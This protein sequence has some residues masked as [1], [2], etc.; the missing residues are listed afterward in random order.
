MTQM[1]LIVIGAIVVTG[2]MTPVTRAICALPSRDASQLRAVP[3]SAI[4]PPPAALSASAA[5]AGAAEVSSA[6]A[7]STNETGQQPVQP[8]EEIARNLT[9]PHPNVRVEAMRTLAKAAHPDAIAHIAVLLT[10]PIDE[11]QSEAIDTLIGFYMIDVPKKSRKIA[12]LIEV[13][14]GSRGERAFERGPFILLPRPSPEALKK[15]LAGAMRDQNPKIRLEATYALGALVPPPAGPDAEAAIAANL[16]DPEGNIRL[17]AARVAGAVRA[18]TITDALVAAINDPEEKIK[19]AAMRS[20]GDIRDPRAVRALEDQF[21]YYQKGTLARAAFDGLSRIADPTSLPL[22]NEQLAS[23]DATLRRLAIEGT[24]RAGDP[25]EIA[26]IEMATAGESDRSA[27]L[28][29]AFA[30]QRASNRG[31]DTI[32][33][34]INDNVLF[35]QAM[36]Y[37]VELGPAIAAP[38]SQHLKDPN[39]QVRER[40]A[41]ALG[42]IGGND[43]KAALEGT[44][45][46]PDVN[47]SRAAERG[48][49]RIRIVEATR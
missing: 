40:I 11:I 2:G 49:A 4:P 42:L 16:R 12:Y 23:R 10:D 43:A 30:S 22:F 48:L 27:Q 45:R 29:R 24:T 32:V 8:F 19:L 5:T 26:A 6:T 17:A 46:D 15:G 9:S 28:A 38:L 1:Q 31:L 33:M 34:R 39:A 36:G 47:V 20:T 7:G 3:L 14:G 18:T 44:L 41:Q 21:R 37:L 13:D 35:E 25:K